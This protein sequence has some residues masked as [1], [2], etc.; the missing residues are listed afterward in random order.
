VLLTILVLSALSAAD[1]T[2][3]VPGTVLRFGTTLER[4]PEYG[5]FTPPQPAAPARTPGP[6]RPAAP[7]RALPAG[8]DVREGPTR[9]FGL[10]AQAT[11]TFEARRLTQARFEVD[12]ISAHSLDYLEDQLRRSGFRRGCLRH[13]PGNWDCRWTGTAVIHLTLAQA[14]LTA[15][16]TPP[17]PPVEPVAAAAPAAPR[18]PPPDEH[19]GPDTLTLTGADSLPPPLAI[20]TCKPVRPDAAKREGVFGRVIVRVLL[21]VD[22]RVLDARVDRSVPMLDEAAL[23]CARRFRFAPYVVSGRPMRVW[24]ELPLTF[25]LD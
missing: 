25:L 12:P 3:R 13:D 10:E 2:Q 16:V 6:R 5:R 18:G 21:D 1:T 23:E 7:V 24:H 11:L 8:T 19:A 4:V 20:E 15:D 9:F 14:R 17:E 22:G